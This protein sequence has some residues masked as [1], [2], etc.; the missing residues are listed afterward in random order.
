MKI[1]IAGASGFIGRHLVTSLSSK[2]NIT[3]LGRDIDRL[4]SNFPQQHAVD[5]P[6][7]QTQSANDYQII[8]NL[9][10]ENIGDMRWTANRKTKI[11]TSRVDT[12]EKLCN[13]AL[14]S[15][16]PASLRLLNASAIGIYGLNTDNNDEKTPIKIQRQCFSQEV[17][18]RW[19]SIV[20]SK[21]NKKIKLHFNAIWCGA[22][23]TRRHVKKT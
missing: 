19:E 3:V 4:K 23:K 2:H 21:L 15:N 20:S 6:S 17:V 9:C 11:L 14:T 12:T 16:N 13:W 7:L 5:W 22:K 10:G 8:I 1:L 18:R